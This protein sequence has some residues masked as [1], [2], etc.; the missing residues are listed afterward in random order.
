MMGGKTYT[1]PLEEFARSAAEIGHKRGALSQRGAC[2]LMN[3]LLALLLQFAWFEQESV[4]GSG[5]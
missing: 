2:L 1:R 4:V 5:F 3:L